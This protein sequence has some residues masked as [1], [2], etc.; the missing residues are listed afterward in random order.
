MLEKYVFE[1]KQSKL[2]D[3]L[4]IKI[5]TFQICPLLYSIVVTGKYRSVLRKKKFALFNC[6]FI[7]MYLNTKWILLF[8]KVDIWSWEYPLPLFIFGNNARNLYYSNSQGSSTTRWLHPP[9]VNREFSSLLSFNSLSF[10]AVHEKPSMK[11]LSYFSFPLYLPSQLS[12]SR[13]FSLNYLKKITDRQL[14]VW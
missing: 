8:L 11:A 2:A 7:Q 12:I 10:S 5:S 14:F 9:T 3:F 1:Y 4:G 13:S 6:N